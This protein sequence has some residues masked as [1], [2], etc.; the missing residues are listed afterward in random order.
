MADQRKSRSDKIRDLADRPRTDPY[1]VLGVSRDAA[2]AEIK[3]AY[4]AAAVRHHPDRNNGD[5]EAEARFKEVGEAHDVL[6][7]EEKRA[8]FDRY[9][10]DGLRWKEA[11]PA[12]RPSSRRKVVD[13]EE[14]NVFVERGSPHWHFGNVRTCTVCGIG[15]VEGSFRAVGGIACEEGPS[16]GSGALPG[17]F[18]VGGIK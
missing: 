5:P 16:S 13:E 15:L 9:G 2:A 4:R 6:S 11:A 3:R 17:A 14:E 7:D 18:A 8:L 1:E 10:V 12:P